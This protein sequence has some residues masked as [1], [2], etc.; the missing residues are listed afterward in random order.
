MDSSTK[1][2]LLAVG[3][4]AG[5]FVTGYAIYQLSSKKAVTTAQDEE[6]LE[7]VRKIGTVKANAQ[8]VFDFEHFV[9]IYKI[10]RKHSKRQLQQILDEMKTK[11]RQLL[12]ED[13]IQEYRQLVL[14]QTKN[15]E[16]I[17]QKVSEQVCMELDLTEQQFTT[18]QQHFM[19]QP[20][21]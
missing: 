17:Y 5:V 3:A 7:D 16:T 11:R 9:E 10:I 18:T 6:L 15:E 13:K 14:E 1:K 8:G 19:Q 20:Q 21:Y 4:A 12:K 2:I